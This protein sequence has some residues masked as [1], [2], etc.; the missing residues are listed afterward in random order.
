MDDVDT[1]A[2]VDRGARASRDPSRGDATRQQIKLTARRLF[3]TQGLDS[4][5][6][7]KIVREAGQKNAGSVNYYFQSKEA[8]IRELILD[9]A[10]LLEAER[11]RLVDELEASAR[12]ISVRD[13]VS[14]LIH[15]PHVDTNG[16]GLDEHAL[17]FLNMVMIDH[18]DLLFDALQGGADRG[19]RRCFAHLRRL[20]SDLPPAIVQQRLMLLMLHLFAV[21]SSREAAR[22]QPDV[23]RSLWGQPAARENAIDTITG[24][25]CCPVSPETLAA[26]RPPSPSTAAKRPRRQSVL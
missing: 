5:S 10:D 13:L 26:M 23:W 17:R 21:C 15:V 4:V 7:R 20:L 14:I 6:I 3:A 9:V 22:A 2:A 19:T 8:L 24:M 11:N 18:R 12:P 25:I 16:A 1:Q